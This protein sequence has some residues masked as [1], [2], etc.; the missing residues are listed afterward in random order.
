MFGPI[1]KIVLQIPILEAES[2]LMPLI[3][4][5]P[6]QVGE[7]Y[8]RFSNVEEGI[9]ENII[10]LST[11]WLLRPRDG[12]TVTVKAR[13]EVRSP[14][15][16]A[17][18]FEEASVGEVKISDGL[19]ALIAPALLPRGQFSLQ[20]LIAIKEVRSRIVD[21]TTYTYH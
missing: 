11:P 1:C 21:L 15:R 20:L 2:R 5:S 14:H 7:I 3:G 13:Y 19:E 17:L 8:Q 10:Q 16:I 4:P 6:V 12:F 9:V 18:T